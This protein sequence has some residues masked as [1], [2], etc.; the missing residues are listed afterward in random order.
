[1]DVSY[2][3]RKFTVEFTMDKL[4]KCARHKASVI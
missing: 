2:L 4:N 1:M 3:T